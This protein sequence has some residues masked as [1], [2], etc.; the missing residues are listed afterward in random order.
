MCTFI[1]GI[2]RFSLVVVNFFLG[3]VSSLFVLPANGAFRLECVLKA[4]RS[5]WYK[6]I[7]V[8]LVKFL[9]YSSEIYERIQKLTG[10]VLLSCRRSAPHC[11]MRLVRKASLTRQRQCLTSS[12]SES[13]PIFISSCV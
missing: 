10:I 7:T 11:Q 5:S 2:A 13:G 3:F 1:P 12:S 6:L 8:Y 4:S 9:L